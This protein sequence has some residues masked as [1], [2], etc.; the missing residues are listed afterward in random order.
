[1]ELLTLKIYFIFM[2]IKIK[3]IINKKIIFKELN[4][5]S[6]SRIAI[7]CTKAVLR[8]SGVAV[9][10]FKLLPGLGTVAGGII[11]FIFDIS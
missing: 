9:D 10:I 4:F 8:F 6:P 7:L 11:N 2:K 3:I 1:M 5:S